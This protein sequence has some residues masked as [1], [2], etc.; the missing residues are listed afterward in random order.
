VVSLNTVCDKCPSPATIRPAKQSNTF[1]RSVPATRG[2]AHT[3]VIIAGSIEYD[4]PA[5]EPALATEYVKRISVRK[6]SRNGHGACKWI[7][8]T[9]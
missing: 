1:P 9:S 6:A 3:T 4:R 2:L 7:F 8:H 5:S